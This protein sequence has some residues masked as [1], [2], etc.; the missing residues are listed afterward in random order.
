MAQFISVTYA[1][2]A[3]LNFN[4]IS[5]VRINQWM[6]YTV[7][8]MSG[9]YCSGHYNVW[10]IMLWF[11]RRIVRHSSI[12]GFYDVLLLLINVWSLIGFYDRLIC[13]LQTCFF[14]MCLLCYLRS[15]CEFWNIFT[16]DI[17]LLSDLCSEHTGPRW[18]N[19]ST[20]VLS[21][22]FFSQNSKRPITLLNYFMVCME[23]LK[24]SLRFKVIRRITLVIS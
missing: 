14:E 13:L 2:L 18:P 21:V 17:L 10:Y 12:C 24:S 1:N 16:C 20:N 19:G 11:L 15:V 3:D 9:F 8:W 6:P 22:L 5:M 23:M 4:D 7:L